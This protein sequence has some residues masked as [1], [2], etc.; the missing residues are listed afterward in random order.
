MTETIESQQKQRRPHAGNWKPGQS[1]NPSGRP[2]GARHK[3]TLAVEALLDGEADTL[4]RKAIELAQAGDLTALR[5][6]LDRIAPPRRD[7]PVSLP[8]PKVETAGDSLKAIA[9]VVDA[10]G[11]G[12]VT[13]SEAGDVVRV[14][15]VFA[16]SAEMIA[17]EA[18]IKALED[19][20]NG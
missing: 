3:T 7:R 1:G 10:L 12:E 8:L 19:K 11:A 5:L 6:C 14:L 15:E 2:V 18:R 4:T 16:K 20:S 13:P 9:T 17:L